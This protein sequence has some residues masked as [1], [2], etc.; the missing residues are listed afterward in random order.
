MPA[1]IC[2]LILD[3]FGSRD[4]TDNNAIL[5]ANTPNIDSAKQTGTHTLIS[6]SGPEVGL[7]EGQMGNSE[8]GHLTIGAGRLVPQALTRIQMEIDQ[9]DFVSNPAL[10]NAIGGSVTD[11]KAL[12]VLGLL[13]PGGVHSHEDHLLALFNMAKEQ[14]CTTLYFHAF[15]DGRD[16]PPKCALASIQRIEAQGAASIASLTGRYYA[17]DR[18]NRWD[19][20]KQ[21]YDL[22]VGKTAPYSAETAEQGLAMAYE[23]GETDEF[24]QAT[25]IHSEGKQSVRIQDGDSVIFMNFRSDRARELTRVFL[26]QDFTEFDRHPLPQLK[27]FVTLTQYHEDFTAEVAYPPLTFHNTLGEYLAKKGLKQLRIAETEKYAHVTFFFNGGVEIPNDNED[28]ILIPSPTVATYDLQPEMSAFE[29]TEQLVNA[30]KSKKYDAII[31]N[32]ANPDMVGHTGNLAATIKAIEAVDTCV[33]KVIEAL[34]EVGGEA[35]ITADHGNAECMLNPET[36]QAH[37]AHTTEPVPF[38]Y[39]GR[40]AKIIKSDGTLAD[41]A[42]TLLTLMGLAIPEEMTGTSIVEFT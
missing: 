1:P 6:G 25:A 34:K 11:N 22:L 15:L 18:D 14:G 19:R 8:V 33:G 3:G 40:P 4:D 41:L 39:V 23:R 24:V 7:P 10:C 2:L 9:G 36:K 30:I 20:I 38:I 13:S 17:M 32:Y 37:T 26:D 27:H 12:H 28:R 5:L 42:P 31:C 29:L 16:T 21:T 35:I